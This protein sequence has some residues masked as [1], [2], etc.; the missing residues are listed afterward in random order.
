MPAAD[1]IVLAAGNGDRFLDPLHRSKL[2]HE[3]QGRPLLVRTLAATR[4]AGIATAH[5]VVGYDR[6]HVRRVC[7]AAAPP[8]LRL[9][10]HVN[11][12]WHLE[13]GLSVLA[14]RASVPSR[15][16]V[17]M[18][19]HVFDPAVLARM[20]ALPV[21]AGASLLAID[22]RLED[23]TRVEEATKVQTDGERIVAIGKDLPA[24]DALD[25]GVFLCHATLFDA[26]EDARREGDT[27]LSGGVRRLARAGRMRAMTIGEAHWYDIDTRADLEAFEAGSR[28]A[29]R[30][31]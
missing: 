10:F 18:G 13:N 31:A 5:V 22:R 15:F 3:I 6:A 20:R 7:V 27:T 25:T 9:V 1:A 30:V 23:A 4:Q 14:A 24:Y 17:L 21:P 8:G 11:E 19:D 12:D 16:A 28:T 29:E 2:L 26:L